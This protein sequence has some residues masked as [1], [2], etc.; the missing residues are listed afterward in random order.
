M[1]V[2]GS[3]AV[4]VFYGSVMVFVA[5]IVMDKHMQLINDK[6]ETKS[7]AILENRVLLDIVV[8]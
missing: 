8:Y 5:Q 3:T 1:T 6:I 4:C 7:I 2:G